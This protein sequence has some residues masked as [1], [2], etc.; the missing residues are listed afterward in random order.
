MTV[1]CLIPTPLKIDIFS[2]VLSHGRNALRFASDG[3]FAY[4]PRRFLRL[5]R[6]R[7]ARV[8]RRLSFWVGLVCLAFIGL[9][10]AAAAFAALV[11]SAFGAF[12][13][14]EDAVAV[15]IEGGELGGDVGLHGGAGERI[16][17]F[18]VAVAFGRCCDHGGFDL[19]LA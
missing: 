18:A 19:R 1:S 17:G 9:G 16:L 6:G 4:T 10:A 12:V 7:A 13:A 5:S 2:R 14:A 8:L 3:A 15:G 11:A